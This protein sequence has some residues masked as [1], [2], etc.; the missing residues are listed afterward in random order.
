MILNSDGK[1]NIDV[2]P[3]WAEA[4]SNNDI[5]HLVVEGPKQAQQDDSSIRTCYL[6]R[7]ILRASVEKNEDYHFLAYKLDWADDIQM[8]S[9]QDYILHEDQII[10]FHRF[11]VV[12]DSQYIDKI[13]Q[14]EI[15]IFDD[16]PSSSYGSINKDK[17]IHCVT[18]ELYFGDV[19]ILEYSIA[20]V[21]F[22]DNILDYKYCRFFHFLPQDNLD[23]KH[24]QFKF[25]NDRN[26]KIC[27]KKRYFRNKQGDVVNEENI[28]FSKEVYFFEKI[29]FR[30]QYAS[31]VF[32]SFFEIATVAS[33]EEI[34]K[35]VLP[36][37]GTS[38]KEE[39]KRFL[40]EV[41]EKISSEVKDIEEKISK[42]IEYV[43]NHIIYI[44][45][46]GVMHG[47][48]PQSVKI[49]IEKQSGDCKAKSLLLVKLLSRLG[50]D[51]KLTLV[52]Y[53]AGLYIEQY[54]PSPFIFNHAI[55]KIYHKGNVYF[56][57]PTWSDRF[58]FLDNRAQ[59]IF[60]HYIEIGGKPC[61]KK[62]SNN[63]SKL[64]SL[65][66]NIFIDIK[67]GKGK[68]KSET[69]YRFGLADDKRKFIRQSNQNRTLQ[70]EGEYHYSKLEYP[71]DKDQSEYI[72][73][74]EYKIINDNRNLNE[75]KDIYTATLL[76]PYLP[77]TGKNNIFK[78]YLSL[79]QSNLDNFKN[80]DNIVGNFFDHFRKASLTI[81]CD[82]IYDYF[83]K[84]VRRDL[85]VSNEYFYFS[86]KKQLS[87]KTV[88][89][90]LEFRPNSFK[91]INRSDL[92]SLRKDFKKINDSNFGVG[93][94]YHFS[95]YFRV[96]LIVIFYILF[97][98]I[99]GR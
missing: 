71:K 34:L 31:D 81:H 90:F 63:Q 41:L 46:A 3:N 57:D 9:V 36:F 98:Y 99:I 4:P 96:A 76:K 48:V 32:T 18:K 11:G 67:K 72:D 95:A 73:D 83:D 61:L 84:I 55:V 35:D 91:E 25:I 94:V 40:D 26:E 77:G 2:A 5:I 69:I 24:Y 37:Y 85:E 74:A 79:N 50:I 7:R 82:K 70:M 89:L 19:L 20:Q 54:M 59:P 13:P 68:I 38:N 16:E 87:L 51:A 64:A 17:K 29:N 42:V 22:K 53:D 10:I 52:N 1:F 8:A 44:F 47:H 6:S 23:Y 39:E 30:A 60:G 14:T 92:E 65:E 12:R 62:T 45:D 33:W 27:V 28:I 49:T 88:K 78:Y 80:K 15:N 97:L 66:D 58:G 75:I 93:I 21:F 86:N 43:Q 56:V